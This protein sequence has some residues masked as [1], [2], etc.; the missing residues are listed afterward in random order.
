MTVFEGGR[1][2]VQ[3]TRHNE[4][5]RVGH[6]TEDGGYLIRAH[7]AQRHFVTVQNVIS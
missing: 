7:S 3:S 5:E 2:G 4:T 1:I 6:L